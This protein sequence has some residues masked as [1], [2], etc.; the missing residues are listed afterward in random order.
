VNHRVNH[1]LDL[2][3]STCLRTPHHPAVVDALG[4]VTYAELDAMSD[5]LAAALQEHGVIAGDL[6]CLV[7]RRSA[8]FAIAALATWRCGAAYVPVSDETPPERIAAILA[9]TGAR[10]IVAVGGAATEL[11]RS[12]PPLP[13]LA[14]KRSN[15]L[16]RRPRAYAPSREDLAYVVFTSGS[17]G[18]PK[19][20][21]IG[22]DSLADVIDAFCGHF[23]IVA[24]D[25]VSAVA[26]IAFD[27]A[28]IEFWPALSRGG[29]VCVA[30]ADIVR[31][32]TSL[33]RWMDEGR[34]TFSWLPTPLAELLIDDASVALP[35][36]L[37]MIETAG[38]RLHKRPRGWRVALENSYGPTETTVI[39]TSSRVRNAEQVRATAGVDAAPDIGRPLPGVTVHVLD[40]QMH[41]VAPG[42][43]G[44][45]YI[46]GIGVGRGYWGRPD[47]T[48]QRFVADPF[49]S[50]PGARL[51]ATGDRCRTNADGNLEF[52]GRNDDQVKLRGH[53]V[54]L[55]E[56]ELALS[57]VEGIAQAACAVV[58]VR[59]VQRLVAWYARSAD[60]AIDRDDLRASLARRL[61]DYMVPE[62]WVGLERLALT[63]NGKVDRARLPIPADDGVVAGD[64]DTL[65][66]D[67]RAFLAW[68]R[69]SIGLPIEWD[70][71]LFR[72]GG[73]SIDAILLMDGLRRSHDL[74]LDYPDLAG[75]SEPAALYARLRAVR[76]GAGAASST[77]TAVVPRSGDAPT[78]LS[79]SQR[80]VW[81]LANI[82]PEDRAYHAKARLQFSGEVCARTLRDA[83]QD[84][85]DRHE[86]FRTVFIETDGE[87]AQQVQAAW[88]VELPTVD[89][90]DVLPADSSPERIGAALDD[91]LMGALNAPFALDR[92]PLVRWL[93]VRLPQG[94][95]ALLHIEHHLVHDGWSYNLFVRELI[96]HYSRRIDAPGTPP[97]TPMPLQYA[98]FCVAQQAWLRSTAAADS[99]AYWRDALTG[100]PAAT[101][102]PSNGD[103]ASTGG[104]TLRKP[105]PRDRWRRIEDFCKRH[106]YTPFSF[107]LSAFGQVLSRASGDSDVCIGS[108]FANRHWPGAG[109]IIGM[110]INTVVL[111]TRSGEDDRV[112]D[113]LARNTRVCH[114]AQIHQAYPFERLVQALNPPREAG[115]NP[116]FQVFLG[117]HDSPLPS[118]RMPGTTRIALTEA[119]DSRAAKFDLSLVVIPREGQDGDDDPVHMLW[120]FKLAR[121]AP[122]FVEALVATFE[123]T[124]DAFLDHSEAPLKS[125]ELVPPPPPRALGPTTTTTTVERILSRA[126]LQPDAIAIESGT[127]TLRY[128]ALAIAIADKAA[129]LRARGVEPGDLVGVSLE[130][131]PDLV[132]WLL[133]VQ[134]AGAAYIPLDPAYP[135]DRLRYIV[136]H[137]RPRC[138]VADAARAEFVDADRL[139]APEASGGATADAGP[140]PDPAAP[141]YV[142]YTSGSTGRPKGVVVG[143]DN[144]S[145]L[146]NA[147]AERFPLTA[148]SRWLAVTSF[149]FDI[150]IVELFMPLIHGARLV[151]ADEEDARDA[152]RLVALLERSG[153]DLMQATPSTWRALV[154]T[155]W[156]PPA[157]FRGLCGGEAIDTALA[158][159]VLARGVDFHNLY[160]PTETT[161][162]SAAH[163]IAATDD[164]IPLGMPL[165]N[166]EIHV[167]DRNRCPVPVGAIGE[168]WIGGEG[169]ARGYLH[170]P[171]LTAERFIPNPF[172]AGRLYAT[173]DLM[174]R[175]AEGRLFFHGRNDHQVKIRGFRIELAEIEAR[176]REVDGIDD[177]VV[178]ANGR[179][180]EARLAAYVVAR[181]DS[182]LDAAMRHCAAGLPEYMQPAHWVALAAMPRTPNG[183]IDR[184]ALPAPE[185]TLTTTD[186]RAPEGATERAVAAIYA[187]LLGLAEPRAG[188]GFIASGGHSLLAMRAVARI[189]RE[190]SIRISVIEFVRLSTIAA[191]ADRVDA[192]RAGNHAGF[193][194]EIVI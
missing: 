162:W 156:T 17:T 28:V 69:A 83:L 37:R 40:P 151:L 129:A 191:V 143:H 52:I 112:H 166:T 176:I 79:A 134:L 189:N 159:Q 101:L 108:A 4:T 111:R 107:V 95:S 1:L 84:I 64:A 90:R 82:A 32:T 66:E 87:A 171:E 9:Q 102:L 51:Y 103:R 116:L 181:D 153:A 89:L 192:L 61:P 164:P 187:E 85:V 63:A 182:L 93:L 24:D 170:A 106:G 7:G 160:G 21:M 183:K 38:Q 45:L 100:A 58:D 126:A 152:G 23:A 49:A 133:A 54:E 48:A 20:V 12:E 161:I 140:G 142:I 27:A 119:V 149:S 157:R 167:L 121:F 188:D 172:G 72:A 185:G 175:D 16:G 98:D 18:A 46:G 132:V 99:E 154:E 88:P 34:I 147:M 55:G 118:L 71:D 26:N 155:D 59:G 56:I 14:P 150:S 174:S 19:G 80:S 60:S 158:R 39:A 139:L 11:P 68:Y 110:V 124:V 127:R 141:A 81:F 91:L 109:E 128:D 177:A 3:A 15:H 6:V 75:G 123:R 97:D 94:C 10:A 163:A 130:R 113:L 180:A 8:D 148:Q 25:R 62:I 184:A 173:G 29:T 74:H 47:L 105:F 131:G 13:M 5:D 22:H 178:V 117:F 57:A 136:E 194:E 138:V 67:Q 70:Q 35:A 168:G 86:I 137:A 122:W 115:V 120:E 76:S 41:P 193:V 96:A 42:E 77:A 50:T 186:A 190:F 114:E 125:L 165:S 144:L 33:L 36:S 92:L 145:S 31:S 65:D 43:V 2:F 146:M 73:N 104:M 44:E 30:S 53:R 179:G 135:A 78:P 169:V